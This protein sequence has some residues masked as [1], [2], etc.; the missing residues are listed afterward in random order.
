MLSWHLVILFN[1]SSI[2]VDVIITI[3]FA[4]R[5][6]KCGGCCFSGEPALRCTGTLEPSRHMCLARKACHSA[7]ATAA[8]RRR[9]GV[10]FLAILLMIVAYIKGVLVMRCCFVV[11]WVIAASIFVCVHPGLNSAV[12][13]ERMM[14]QNCMHGVC[15]ITKRSIMFRPS[16]ID[17][18]AV[19]PPPSTQLS[20]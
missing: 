12:T 4:S 8:V 9:T 15:I 14:L 1:C 13:S 10:F 16:C 3:V 2:D 7:A 6:L 20:T 17:R 5:S 18:A 19:R 11:C